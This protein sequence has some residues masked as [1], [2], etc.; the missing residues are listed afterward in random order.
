VYAEL[1]NQSERERVQPTDTEH[2]RGVRRGRASSAARP[3]RRPR[4]R[5]GPAPP[6][7]SEAQKATWT[8]VSEMGNGQPYILGSRMYSCCT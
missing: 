3:A 8:M 7:A 5:R 1:E 2:G 6:L 4:G